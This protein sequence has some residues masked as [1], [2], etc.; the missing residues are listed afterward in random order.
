MD[1]QVGFLHRAHRDA[2]REIRE[3][4]GS[5]LCWSYFVVGESPGSLGNHFHREKI[6]ELYFLEGEGQ[7]LIALVNEGGKIVGKT[8]THSV[9]PH[10][11]VVIP[12]MYAHR[13]DL[14]TGTRFL[15]RSS[16]PFDPNDLRKC[17]IE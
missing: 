3:F 6:E 11:L 15:I 12:P 4:N 17:P 14:A 16:V 9:G 8:E 7:V 2:R 13:L 10:I 1:Y 5:G